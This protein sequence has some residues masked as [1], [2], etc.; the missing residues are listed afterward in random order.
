MGDA[1]WDAIDCERE[2]RRQREQEAIVYM[3]NLKQKQQIKNRLHKLAEKNKDYIPNAELSVYLLEIRRTQTE[4]S[5]PKINC[6]LVASDKYLPREY[7][8]EA[9]YG[10]CITQKTIDP[11]SK[12][13]ELSRLEKILKAHSGKVYP[14]KQTF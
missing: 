5:K 11:D 10:V 9:L 1:N 2:E 6:E 7:N 14:I 3:E 13:F 8:R 4:N 12:T